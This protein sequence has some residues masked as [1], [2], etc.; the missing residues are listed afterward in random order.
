MAKFP[1]LTHSYLGERAEK[2]RSGA[3]KPLPA[4]PLEGRRLIFVTPPNCGVGLGGE[5]EQGVEEC[6][7][8]ANEKSGVG[9]EL[10]LTFSIRGTN[11]P[12]I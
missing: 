5:T 8:L 2:R 12:V 4:R 7:A 10:W 11:L 6:V 1:T 3:R 9:Q